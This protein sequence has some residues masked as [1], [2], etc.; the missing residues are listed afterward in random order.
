MDDGFVGTLTLVYAFPVR[1]YD[2]ETHGLIMYRAYQA[3]ELSQSGTGSVV[4]R[5]GLDRLDIPTPFNIY[6]QASGGTPS[7]AAYYDNTTSFDTTAAHTRQPNEYER[8][9]MQHLASTLIAAP[10]T[11]WLSGDPMLIQMVS[12]SPFSLLRTG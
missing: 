10:N 6:W 8:C 11:N 3:S 4:A 7:Q 5:L 2:A 9:Q 12:Q 1:A